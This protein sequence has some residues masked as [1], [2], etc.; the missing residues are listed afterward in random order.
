MKSFFQKLKFKNSKEI[1]SWAV[2]DWA[3]SAWTTT[4]GTAFFATFFKTEYWN[5]GVDVVETTARYANANSIASLIIVILGPILGSIADKGSARKKFLLFF[6][7]LGSIVTAG[8]YFVGEGN[9]QMA[10]FLF[11]LGSVGFKGGILFSDSMLKGIAKDDN[12][13]IVSTFGYSL[14]YLGGGLLLAANAVIFAKYEMFG[15]PDAAT[16]V[17]INFVSVGI[18]WL[19]FTIPLMLYVKE[20]KK[21]RTESGIKMITGGFSQLFST[22][23]EIR[24]LKT[25]SLFLLGY[26]FYID[27]VDTVIIMAGDYGMSIGFEM[28]KLIGAILVAQFVAFPS[29]LAY[30]YLGNK[31]GIKKA[32]FLA[33]LVYIFV[34]AWAPFMTKIRDFYILAVIVGLFQGGIQAL[35]RSFFTRLI[36]ESKS[37]E[38]FGFYNVLTK[39]AAIIGPQLVGWVGIYVR[40][41]GYGHIAPR[42]GIISLSLLLIAGGIIFYF[43]DEEKG[44]EE[45]KF[46]AG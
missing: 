23:K 3:N 1:W 5:P 46:L 36:P 31:I 45:A 2:Y 12:V 28:D 30:G 11:I 18:W 37:G 25:V 19:V 10:A 26:W 4:V 39:F 40:Y 7:F 15:I 8:L 44:K 20:P 17:K 14:G 13:D 22:F 42:I 41:L 29:A 34:T 33:I 16:A 43:V 38:F 32:I 35:S 27:A 24:H 6:T 21:P 9:W